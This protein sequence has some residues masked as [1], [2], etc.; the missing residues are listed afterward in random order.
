MSPVS[1]STMSP[2]TTS[3]A[4]ISTTL[5]SRR[6]FAFRL[7]IFFKAS[8]AS[9]A[10]YSCTQPST[11]LITTMAAMTE[12]SAHSPTKPLMIIAASSIH[13][14]GLVNCS[15]KMRKREIL[16]ASTIL[17]GPYSV[18]RLA[19]S[20]DDSPC[21]ALVFSSRRTAGTDLS[22]QGIHAPRSNVYIMFTFL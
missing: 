6:T 9:S 1:N 15:R 20:S 12:K 13:T 19:A 3:E 8:M 10:R 18:N 14:N 11:A 2:G 7:T 4:S 22:N 5:P 16:W 21:S 17:L